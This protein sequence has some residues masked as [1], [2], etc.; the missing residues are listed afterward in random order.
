[1]GLPSHLSD[2]EI[3]GRLGE[4]G[5]SEVWLGRHMT[6]GLPVVLKTIKS[7]MLEKGW[8]GGDRVIDEARLMARITNPRVVRA[9]DAGEHDGTPYLVQEYVD[10]STSR[11][12]I[13][14]GARRSGSDYRCGSSAT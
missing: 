4:G 12:S 8:V 6:L 5:M 7:K 14:A 2:Y 9:L 11:S 1:M 13:V 10:G 3:W